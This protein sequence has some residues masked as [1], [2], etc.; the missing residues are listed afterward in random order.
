MTLQ[1]CGAVAPRDLTEAP[2]SIEGRLEGVQAGRGATLL[3]PRAAARPASGLEPTCGQFFK[4][5]D[6]EG[7]L[8]GGFLLLASPFLLLFTVLSAPLE[9]VRDRM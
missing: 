7:V 6:R 5:S 2:A 1:G 4:L 3:L 8:L 9:L